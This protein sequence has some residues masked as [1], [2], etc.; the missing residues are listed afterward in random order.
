MYVGK[1]TIVPWYGM[2]WVYYVFVGMLVISFMFKGRGLYRHIEIQMFLVSHGFLAAQLIH[3]IQKWR[4]PNSLEMYTGGPLLRVTSTWTMKRSFSHEGDKQFRE[5]CSLQTKYLGKQHMIKAYQL[6]SYTQ[7]NSHNII[8]STGWVWGIRYR[9][10]NTPL[11][12]HFWLTMS[13]NQLVMVC[14]ATSFWENQCDNLMGTNNL[15]LKWN[16]KSFH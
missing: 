4:Y 10:T 8:G 1:Y 11:H 14:F 6:L 16:N 2:G 7:Y 5:Q 9:P 3:V 12:R 13:G 15:P